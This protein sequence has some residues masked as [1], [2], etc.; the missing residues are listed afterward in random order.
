MARVAAVSAR[1]G[2]GMETLLR[3]I[4]DALGEDP[5]VEADFEFSAADGEH[6]ALLHRQGN[7]IS[8]R[9]EGDRVCVRAR[10][11]QSLRERLEQLAAAPAKAPAD[12]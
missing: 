1:T 8:T 5:L 10:V 2:E 12:R 11:T 6:L 7:V 9:V 3:Q 4:D